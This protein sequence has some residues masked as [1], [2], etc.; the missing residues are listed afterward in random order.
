MVY[1]TCCVSAKMTDRVHKSASSET[2]WTTRRQHSRQDKVSHTPRLHP[3][4]RFPRG[5]EQTAQ[6]SMVFH[7]AIRGLWLRLP[8]ILLLNHAPCYGGT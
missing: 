3:T 1:F 4:A 2:S 8:V 7:G 6:L 5:T